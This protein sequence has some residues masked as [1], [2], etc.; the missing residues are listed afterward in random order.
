MSQQ[1]Q[2][3]VSPIMEPARPAAAVPSTAPTHP[4]TN[5]TTTTQTTT[6]TAPTHPA[7]APA[8][9]GSTLAP[10]T[11]DPQ[12]Y[13]DKLN[14][15]DRKWEWKVGMRVILLL[16][17]II[18]MGCAAWVVNTFTS[19]PMYS[20]MFYDTDDSWT[21]PW[22]LITFVLSILWSA[23]CLLVF[24]LRKD[25]HQMAP[26]AQ[27]GIDL[28]LWLGYIGTGLLAVSATLSVASFGDRGI[29]G[30]YSGSGPWGYSEGN[31]TW[32]YNSSSSSYYTSSRSSR[33]C[34]SSSSSSSY[35][36]D[37]YGFAN[38]AEVDDYVNSLWQSK[39]A[40]F[41]SELT[42]T[43]CQFIAL[44]LHLTLFIWAC[45]D[46][47]RKNSSKVSKDAEKLA[48]DII[49]NMIK[50]GAIIP[51]TPGQA[52]MRP[53]AP[54]GQQGYPQY[55][56]YQQ[57]PQYQQQPMSQTVPQPPQ[58]S[59]Q[60]PQAGGRLP[61]QEQSILQSSRNEKSRYV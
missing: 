31:N 57:H 41:N 42:A 19:K 56:Q 5:E 61:P 16:V 43:V 32:T 50:T 22:V 38:C 58:T 25:H 17:S 52:Y 6:T 28:I 29:I 37:N 1:Q 23:A 24:F 33:D 54:Q 35:R 49:Q 8:S 2:P 18:G 3:Q 48:A 55:A 12:T 14:A 20:G 34:D 46:T 47:H 40:R 9:T 15:G 7:V 53:M 4:T 60:A 21:F 30:N 51:A 36:Y 13:Y 45:V 27:V 26:G 39:S 10:T 59:A 11:A 44:F